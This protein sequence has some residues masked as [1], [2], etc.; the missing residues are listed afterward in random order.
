MACT[1]CRAKWNR[2]L[3]ERIRWRIAYAMDHV[4]GQCWSNLVSFA[5]GS[6]RWPWQPVG[7]IC[8][9]DAEACGA[10]YC[11]RLKA[12]LRKAGDG[13]LMC[14]QCAGGNCGRALCAPGSGCECPCGTPGH[15]AVPE[16]VTA[17]G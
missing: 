11:G 17:H 6:R 5:L 2:K 8:R 4:P 13:R 15:G 3:P 7:G 14:P 1:P 16:A 9:S 10:C 12:P